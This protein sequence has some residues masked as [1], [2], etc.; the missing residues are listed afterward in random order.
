M[1]VL[2]D[3]PAW[4]LDPETLLPAC[5]APLARTDVEFPEDVDPEQARRCG[6]AGGKNAAARV[7]CEPTGACARRKRR[8]RHG[9]HAPS[10]HECATRPRRCARR[11][12]RASHPQPPGASPRPSLLGACQQYVF[13]RCGSR[14]LRWEGR[15]RR[16]TC[17]PTSPSRAARCLSWPAV[18]G[19]LTR[20]CWR[21]RG[22][23]RAPLG[24]WAGRAWQHLGQ[25]RGRPRKL[26]ERSPATQSS[27]LSIHNRLRLAPHPRGAAGSRIRR[28]PGRAGPWTAPLAR[29]AQSSCRSASSGIHRSSSGS[30]T[31]PRG[32]SAPALNAKAPLTVTSASASPA[33]VLR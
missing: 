10:C 6:L 7:R 21:P 3:A 19:S 8:G 5:R 1:L 13:L 28:R 30:R 14:C 32:V 27:R 11:S 33:R 29:C 26:E 22:G 25:G 4:A 15:A 20:C 23:W 2:G 9:W 31:G 24:P 16:W 12:R 17:Q 18:W